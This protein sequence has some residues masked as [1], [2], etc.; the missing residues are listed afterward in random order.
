MALSGI[1][2]KQLTMAITDMEMLV[3]HLLAMFLTYS[4]DGTNVCGSKR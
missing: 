1:A 4:P 2:V 3:V